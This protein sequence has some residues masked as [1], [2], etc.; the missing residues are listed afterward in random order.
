MAMIS[1]TNVNVSDIG[2]TL[3]NAGGSVTVNEP[4]TY[5]TTSAKINMWSKYKPVPF[6]ADFPDF[7]SNWWKGNDGN[8]GINITKYNSMEE[9]YNATVGSTNGW[10]YDLPTGGESE[11]FRLGDFRG[12][13]TEAV[14]PIK[15]FKFPERAGLNNDA[16]ATFEYNT[17]TEDS[18]RLVMSDFGSLE[19]CYLGVVIWDTTL[20]KKIAWNTTSTT[21]KAG[22]NKVTV[23]MS[24]TY[25]GS[26]YKAVPFLCTT[27]QIQGASIQSAQY[28]TVP[29]ANKASVN[30]VT[31]LDGLTIWAEYYYASGATLPSSLKYKF[32]YA[33]WSN[34][35]TSSNKLKLLNSSMEAIYT[36]SLPDFTVAYER[37]YNYPYDMNGNEW[38]S[39]STL[40]F[41]PSATKWVRIEINNNRVYAEESIIL[42]Q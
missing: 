1:K 12:Y 21:I 14:P 2:N 38:E 41:D 31:N 15:G 9:I 33:N 7:S 16:S 34:G 27:T 24:V 29:M 13:D 35:A 39:I 5:F 3:N 10:S 28:Y 11:P 25:T 19:N 40:N 30:V 17:T 23:K 18:P 42:P 22:A 26:R 36:K 8:C 20:N 37:E 4:L 32:R 6:T